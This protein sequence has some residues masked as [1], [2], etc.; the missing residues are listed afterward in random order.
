MKMLFIVFRESMVEQVHA[1][2]KSYDVTAFT[3]LQN[4]GGKGETGPTLHFSL[5]TGANRIILAAV[6]EQAAYRL[7]DGFTRFRAEHVTGAGDKA[8]PLHV[9]V[10]PCE[11]V[12]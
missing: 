11:Q 2:L 10:L 7:I 6:A 9:F 12:V 1:L 3:E 4:V 8:L 5:S